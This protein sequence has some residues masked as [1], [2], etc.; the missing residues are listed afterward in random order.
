VYQS[1]VDSLTASRK[2][3]IYINVIHPDAPFYRMAEVTETEE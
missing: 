3:P 1:L 2:T